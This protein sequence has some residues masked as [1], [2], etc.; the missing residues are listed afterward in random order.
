MELHSTEQIN[1]RSNFWEDEYKQRD[2][3]RRKLLHGC[4]ARE[5]LQ[6]TGGVSRLEVVIRQTP[7]G[8]VRPDPNEPV[9][10]LLS[11]LDLGERNLEPYYRPGSVELALRIVPDPKTHFSGYYIS[12]EALL[13]STFSNDEFHIFTCECGSPECAGIKSGVD[14]VHEDGLVVWRMRGI[15]PRRVVVFDSPQYRGEILEKIRAGLIAHRELGADAC[16]NERRET[17][18]I[19]RLWRRASERK[20]SGDYPENRLPLTPH[21]DLRELIFLVGLEPSESFED[22]KKKVIQQIQSKGFFKVDG[23]DGSFIVPPKP[24][25]P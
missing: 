17:E 12:A 13:A 5:Y 23:A 19:E 3:W 20:S 21:K 16:F 25:T 7:A 1:T 18:G 9:N 2:W 8:M 6:L 10:P 15:S 22:F 24:P 4:T 11:D 14:V